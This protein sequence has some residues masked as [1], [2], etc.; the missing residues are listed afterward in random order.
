MQGFEGLLAGHQLAGRYQIEKVIGRGGFAAVYS[1][2]D[3]RLGRTVAVKVM[4]LT[5]SKPALQEE[6]RKR[7]HREA[8]AIARLHHPN[9][10]TVFDFGTDPVLGLDFLVME[11]LRGEDLSTRL[12]R[13]D[14]IPLDFA[15]RILRD[16]TLGVNEGH[17]AGLIHRDVKPGNV[18]LVPG[19]QPDFVRVCVL[20]FGI[21]RLVGDE[22][23]QLTHSGGIAMSPA[24]ASPEQIRGER[25]VTPASDVFSLGAIGY[26]LLARERP[27]AGNRLLQPVG[28]DEPIP[29]WERDPALPRPVAEVIHR[30]L[31]AEPEDRYPDAGAMAEA[32]AQA[33]SEPETRGVV[34][35]PAPVVEPD[36]SSTLASPPPEEAPAVAWVSDVPPAPE[37]TVA[38]PAAEAPP[39]QPTAPL[40]IPVPQPTRKLEPK[41]RPAAPSVARA[42]AKPGAR[43][44]APLAALLLVLLIGGA[45]WAFGRRSGDEPAPAPPTASRPDSPVTPAAT[46]SDGQLPSADDPG[47]RDT[48]L[49]GIPG[50]AEAPPPASASDPTQVAASVSDRPEPPPPTVAERPEAPAKD[51]AA[52]RLNR[53][54]EGAFERGEVSDAVRRLRAAVQRDPGNVLFR[55]NLGWALF[56]AGQ[57]D[58]ARRE[59]EQ[60]IRMNPRRDI[61]YANLGEVKW[62]QGDRAG[63]IAAYERFLELNSDPRRER[64]A[65]EKLRRMRQG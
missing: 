34:V 46:P 41:P 5:P 35:P 18:F 55:N 9:V 8:K 51:A 56:E 42:P 65:R 7:F 38:A 12:A 47:A 49:G 11:L 36:T 19:D 10:V 43:R 25:D 4:T 58:E 63:A 60:V 50:E 22:A 53:E 26:E 61:A 16:A 3:E 2:T 64:I 27:F 62:K 15:L 31:A 17:K 33:L 14:P 1:A 44:F 40:A 45:V 37:P 23:T 32:L 57:L 6:V 20:D 54:G 48:M 59:L 13:P 30:A 39:P 24:Y 52:R 21:A 29:L 28:P